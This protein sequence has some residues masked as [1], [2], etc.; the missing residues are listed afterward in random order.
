MSWEV[1]F[2]S[3]LILPEESTTEDQDKRTL[4]S[5]RTAVVNAL[6]KILTNSVSIPSTFSISTV[7]ILV[8][9][10]GRVSNLILVLQI[11]NKLKNGEIKNKYYISTKSFRLSETECGT[12]Y[13]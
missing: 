12:S 4:G 7:F 6:L 11:K 1:N 13:K 9:K 10:M 8:K 3:Y 5:T 2:P